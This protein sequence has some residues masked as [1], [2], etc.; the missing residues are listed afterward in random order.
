MNVIK[1]ILEQNFIK[2]NL[3]FDFINYVIKYSIARNLE[4]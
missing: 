1:N 2:N 4:I 3:Y